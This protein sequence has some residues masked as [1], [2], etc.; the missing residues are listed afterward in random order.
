MFIVPLHCC[1]N[2]T[3]PN[4]PTRRL[5]PGNPTTAASATVWGLNGHRQWLLG[6][7]NWITVNHWAKWSVLGGVFRTKLLLMTFYDFLIRH[8]KK[9]RKVMFLWNL[10]KRKIRILE[11]WFLSVEASRP[12][13]PWA[14]ARP[15]TA[16]RSVQPILQGSLAGMPIMHT[17]T[18]TTLRNDVCGNSSHVMLCMQRRLSDSGLT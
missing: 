14:H 1:Q 3:L 2:L 10:K 16:S 17:D 7:R 11:H 5:L 18:Q 9:K 8:F 13:V 15:P 6:A 4:C 12:L